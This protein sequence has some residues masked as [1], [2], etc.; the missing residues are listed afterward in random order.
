M[1]ADAPAPTTGFPP[2]FDA[3]W[4]GLSENRLC[5]PK[6]ARC[7]R[8]N[9]YPME[10]CTQCLGSDFDMQEIS[11]LG[12]LYSWT[13]VRRAFSPKQAAWIPYVVG[14]VEFDEVP[15]S[16]LITNII[17]CGF[18]KLAID[19]PVEPV[20]DPGEDPPMV[21]FRPV[22]PKEEQSS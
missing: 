1:T 4:Q 9:W 13:I 21:R 5:F 20:F 16:R 11:G 7:G 12:R 10:R 15:G 17:D 8:V 22:R 6:C 14:L 3:F 2:E 18:D 19:M